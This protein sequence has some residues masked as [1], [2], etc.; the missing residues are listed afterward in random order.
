[1]PTM[2]PKTPTAFPRVNT[3]TTTP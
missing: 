1:M 3:S 2:Q